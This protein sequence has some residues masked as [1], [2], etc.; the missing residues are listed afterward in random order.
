MNSQEQIFKARL[1][2]E[3]CCDICNEV[4]HHHFDCPVCDSKDGYEDTDL[5][6]E[7][8]RCLHEFRCETC[9]TEFVAVEPFE[10][11]TEFINF[12]KVNNA[13]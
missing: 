7:L 11:Y 6:S 10:S 13:P 8:E 4:I 1:Y 3:I 5:Y 2:T 12:K 9:K